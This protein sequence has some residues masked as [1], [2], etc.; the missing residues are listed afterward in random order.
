MGKSS[1]GGPGG[2]RSVVCAVSSPPP[3]AHGHGYGTL[4]YEGS[5]YRAY[6]APDRVPTVERWT[7]S[8]FDGDSWVLVDEDVSIAVRLFMLDLWLESAGCLEWSPPESS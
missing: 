7:E 4:E 6:L 5:T 2:V 1:S 8:R 3:Q